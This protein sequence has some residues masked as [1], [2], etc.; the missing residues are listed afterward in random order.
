MSTVCV[1]DDDSLSHK[2]ISTFAFDNVDRYLLDCVIKLA[3][4]LEKLKGTIKWLVNI[5]WY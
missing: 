2:T 3:G 4:L 1:L 5:E